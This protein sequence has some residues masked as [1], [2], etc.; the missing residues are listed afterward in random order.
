MYEARKGNKTRYFLNLE[1]LAKFFGYDKCYAGQKVRMGYPWHEY[2]VRKMPN[3]E[4]QKVLNIIAE[5][6]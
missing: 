6:M 2:V 3:E 1:E 4:A 5:V